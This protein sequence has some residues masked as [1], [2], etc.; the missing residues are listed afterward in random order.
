MRL[1]QQLRHS[2]A[3]ATTV[4]LCLAASACEETLRSEAPT[5][6]ATTTTASGSGGAGGQS[7]S[8]SASSGEGAA[9]FIS[10]AA[11]GASGGDGGAGGQFDATGCGDGIIQPG[12]VCDDGNN[13]PGDGCA[14]DCKSVEQD[15]AC[16][17]PNQPCVSTVVCGDGLVS[18]KESCDDGNTAGA[19]GCS[20]NCTVESGWACPVPNQKCVAALCGDGILAGKEECEDGNPVPT[21][22]DGCSDTCRREFGFICPTVGSGCK[23]TVCGDGKKEGDEPCDD[24]NDTIGDGCNPFC[25]VEPICGANGCK[26]SCGDGMILPNDNEQCDDGNNQDGDGCSST[27][28]V[29]LGFKCGNLMSQLPNAMEVPVTYRDLITHPASGQTKHPDL[30]I[31]SGNTQTVGL[32]QSSLNAGGKPIYTGICELNNSIGPCPFGPQTTSKVWFDTWYNDSLE[33]VK[34]IDTLTLSKQPDNS[35]F[36]PDS[37]FFPLDNKGQISKGNELANANGHN[38]GF[39]SEVRTWFEFSGGETLNFSGD[40]DVWV[41]VNGKLALDLGGMHPSVSGQFTLD[42]PTATSLGL[43]T[44][45]VYEIVLFHAERRPTGSNFNLTLSGFTRAKSICAS[46]CGDGIVAGDELCDD[47]VNDGSYGGCMPDCTP[48]PRCGDALVQNP[49]EACDDGVNLSNYSFTKM[50]G[51]A[52]SCVLGAYCGDGSV[53]SLFGEECDDGSNQGGYDGCQQDCTLG[54]RCGD[55]MVD[56]SF[57]EECDDGNTV[58]ADGCTANC[59]LET[60]K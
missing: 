4:T 18:G 21:S 11:S 32:V 37:S 1:P 27:C 23:K 57:G 60:P 44:G 16:P 58:G 35:Y 50:P 3:I 30:N 17:T 49:P 52:P 42:T 29:E 22:G 31:F 9:D 10:S 25:E 48:G 19:D 7:S 59:K 20:A 55:G 12:E 43:V 54:P 15:F 38:Y 2:I 40:D 5:T 13:Q 14:G 36:F 24:G 45:N 33:S 34:V 28:Q 8:P 46:T 6:T 39:T 56:K 41:F 53:Q 47:G 51:C 26:S